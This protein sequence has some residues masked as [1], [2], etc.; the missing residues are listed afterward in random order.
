M[1]KTIINPKETYAPVSHYSQLCIASGKKW[2]FVSGVVPLDK[3]GNLIGRGDIRAQFKQILDNL[4]TQLESQG[5][6]LQNIVY[7]MTLLRNEENIV[8]RFKA[9][10]SELFPQY[11]TDG[12]Y[13][14]STMF[15]VCSLYREDILVEY[16]AL[17][18]TD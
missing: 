10:R 8:E 1:E 15:V 12:V 4:K 9:A 7:T 13:P 6:S 2:V 11:F 17:A 5:A 3:S 14:A 16:E 18:I